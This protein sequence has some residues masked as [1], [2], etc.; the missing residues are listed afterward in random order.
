METTP[1]AITYI[2]LDSLPSTDYIIPVAQNVLNVLL[3]M[4][5]MLPFMIL[6]RK[7]IEFSIEAFTTRAIYDLENEKTLSTIVNTT[8]EDMSMEKGF[9]SLELERS[10]F[11][12]WQ[13]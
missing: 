3:V 10:V 5:C 2:M 4:L 9:R 12:K 7:L 13:K 8:I 1:V 11:S 6:F